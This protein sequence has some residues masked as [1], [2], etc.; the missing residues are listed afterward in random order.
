MLVARG[1]KTNLQYDGKWI[2]ITST[3]ISS[4]IAQTFTN[5]SDPNIDI[6]IL[7]AG[8]PCIPLFMSKYNNEFEILLGSSC[9]NYKRSKNNQ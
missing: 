7:E 1:S 4:A 5:A 6:Y 8:T 2:N 3:S 9:C